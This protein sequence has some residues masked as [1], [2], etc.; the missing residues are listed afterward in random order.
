MRIISFLLIA[1][2]AAAL[3]GSALAQ[4][5]SL[6]GRP[7]GAAPTVSGSWLKGK[8][9]GRHH[10]VR[11]GPGRHHR[12]FDR[13]GDRFEGAY[14]GIASVEDFEAVDPHGNGF[15]AGGGGEVRL[16]GGRPYYD[17]D[18]SYPYEWASARDGGARWVA[19]AVDEPERC[20]SER[21]VRVCRGR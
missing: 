20:A 13:G 14:G 7:S 3:S 5:G 18:R 21:G 19:E 6:P 1:G 9:F 16:N 15:F 12:R 11:P 2:G 10:G 4:S 17:Y 8:G